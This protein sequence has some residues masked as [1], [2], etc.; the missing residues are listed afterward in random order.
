M[1]GWSVTPAHLAALEAVATAAEERRAAAHTHRYAY[2]EERSETRRALESATLTLDAALATLRAL[3]EG[4]E[5]ALKPGSSV[6]CCKRADGDEVAVRVTMEDVMI[7]F[8]GDDGVLGS[9]YLTH[10]QV[11]ELCAVLA[12]VR[13]P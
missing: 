8:R 12:R 9:I 7:I 2:N 4:E 5:E 10:A 1:A 11:A 6:V 13:V 3:P